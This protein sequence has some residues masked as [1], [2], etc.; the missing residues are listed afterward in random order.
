MLLLSFHTRPTHPKLIRGDLAEDYAGMEAS[1]SAS[2][3][4]AFNFENE[5]RYAA[6]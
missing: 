1:C 2:T 5:A 4:T 6:P 3:V